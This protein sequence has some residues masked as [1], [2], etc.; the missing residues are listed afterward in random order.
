[1]KSYRV[2]W[3]FDVEADTPEDAAR[4]ALE[5][6]RDPESIATVWSALR[7]T[8]AAEIRG[9]GGPDQDHPVVAIRHGGV[10]PARPAHHGIAAR[11]ARTLF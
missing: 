1:M 8:G 6:M 4:L 2:Q 7:S 10:C 11:T 5:A 9:R 3:E